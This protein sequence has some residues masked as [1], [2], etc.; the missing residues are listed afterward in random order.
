MRYEAAAQQHH[1]KRKNKHP[2]LK[3]QVGSTIP[4]I[5]FPRAHTT[6]PERSE[7]VHRPFTTDT[8]EGEGHADSEYFIS[9]SLSSQRRQTDR[10][11]NLPIKTWQY[12]HLHPPSPPRPRQA[13]SC[14]VVPCSTV[15][16]PFPSLAQ[17]HSFVSMSSSHSPRPRRQLR[18]ASIPHHATPYRVASCPVRV[19]QQRDRSLLRRAGRNGTRRA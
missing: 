9:L 16:A 6:H 8:G 10:R 2:R 15:H 11:R 3:R 13:M 5:H 1:R 17:T 18:S 7:Q 12:S 14:R 19:T 4:Y